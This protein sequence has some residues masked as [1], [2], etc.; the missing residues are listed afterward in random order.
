MEGWRLHSFPF[1]TIDGIE[2]VSRTNSEKIS[3]TIDGL[4]GV[5]SHASEALEG[6]EPDGRWTA[7]LEFRCQKRW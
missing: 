3:L 7:L 5:V 1:L 6:D 4:F 2:G